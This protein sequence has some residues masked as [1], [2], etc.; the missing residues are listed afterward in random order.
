MTVRLTVK[1][2]PAAITASKADWLAGTTWLGFTPTN[3]SLSSRNQ[4]EGTIQRQYADGYVIEYITEQFSEPNPGFESDP[5]YLDEKES[6]RELAG[7]LIAVHKLRTSARPL[8]QI[9]GD[10]EFKRLQDMWAQSDKRYRWSVAFPI[11]ETYRIVGHPKAK[12][13]FGEVG[14]RR[15]YQ[16]SS[17]TLRELNDEERASLE[18]LELE[19]VQATNA[20]I[21]IEDEFA[22]AEGSDI[23]PRTEK[24]IGRDLRAGALEGASEEKKAN[25]RKRASWLADSFIRERIR[26]GRLICDDCGFD[27][28]PIFSSTKIMLRS[29]LDVHHKCPLDEGVRYTTINDFALLCPTCHR[30]EHAR[31]KLV[32]LHGT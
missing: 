29:L 13:V 10:V 15:L 21:G 22:F 24:L 27:P 4:C 14:Y 18:N 1:D 20:W 25:V 2:L 12:D 16:R 32:A 19:A 30:I 3:G 9:L 8:E 26:A 11:I 5:E 17:A 6:H 28:A 31:L 23:D 7:R